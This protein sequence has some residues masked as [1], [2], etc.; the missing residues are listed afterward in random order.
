[1]GDDPYEPEQK[2]PP[3][4]DI[5]AYPRSGNQWPDVPQFRETLYQYRTALLDFSKKLMR[6]IAL[7][8]DLEESYF[9]HMAD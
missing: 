4:F 1:M 8:L 6:M 5:S 7:A 3:A 9:D 2:V